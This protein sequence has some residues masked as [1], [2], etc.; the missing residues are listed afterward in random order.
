ML[1]L[2]HIK[3]EAQGCSVK[4]VS[5]S[6]FLEDS[7][8]EGQGSPTSPTAKARKMKRPR[9]TPSAALV[10][11]LLVLALQASKSLQPIMQ[12]A[13]VPPQPTPK[14]SM[15][16]VVAPDVS[17]PPSIISPTVIVLDPEV[18][19]PLALSLNCL[20]RP[21]RASYNDW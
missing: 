18:V 10:M 19:V 6:P 17:A 2:S 20:F 1:I 13:T 3:E 11:A 9:S 16:V 14:Q 8:L 4:F 21:L 12:N 15:L 7:P 5:L